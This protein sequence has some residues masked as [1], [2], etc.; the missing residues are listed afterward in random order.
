MRNLRLGV[1]YD[2]TDFAGWQRQPGV[3]TV[4]QTLEEAAARIVGHRVSVVG[5]GRTDQGVHALGQVAG[6]RTTSRI[7][8]ARLPYA[9][10]TGLPAS[11]RVRS[12]EDVPDTFHA[13]R[14][15]TGKH[16]RYTIWRDPIPHALLNRFALTFPGPLYLAAMA[17]AAGR[18][19]GRRDFRAFRGAAKGQEGRETTKEVWSVTVRDMTPWLVIDVLGSGFL[20]SQVRTMTGTLLEVGRGK[21]APEAVSAILASGDRRRAGPTAPPHGLCLVRVLYDPAPPAWY[22]PHETGTGFPECVPLAP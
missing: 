16:Y 10:N 17:E 19:Q 4:Q 5:A 14:S 13:C 21:L 9:I 7:A 8:A 11:V 18:M 6:F 12:A 3:P 15:A 2:G 20:Y 22:R 1:E